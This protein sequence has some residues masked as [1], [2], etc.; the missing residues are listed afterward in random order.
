[1]LTG[2]LVAVAVAGCGG[3]ERRPAADS[4]AKAT[5]TP[6]ATPVVFCAAED[7]SDFEQGV[8]TRFNRLHADDGMQVRFRGIPDAAD[9]AYRFLANRLGRGC[10]VALPDVTWMGRFAADGRLLDVTDHVAPRTDEFIG[11]TLETARYHGRYWGVPAQADTG[12]LYYRTDATAAPKT[13]QDVYA[14]AQRKHGLLY[15]TAT[16]MSLAAHF[17]EVAYA[18]GG[19]VA[20][21]DG[22]HSTIDSPQNLRALE[23]M[24]DG[25][26]HG[27]VPKTVLEMNE[28]KARIAFEAGRATF[29]RNWPY[30]Y[31]LIHENPRV[32][33]RFAVAPLPAFAGHGAAGVL[34]GKDAV[35]AKTT[36]DRAA[37]L[38]F[39]DLLTSRKEAER[40]ARSYA[41]TPA[42]KAVYKTDLGS[43]MPQQDQIRRALEIA[44]P[45]PVTPAWQKVEEVIASH[46]YAVLIGNAPPELALQDAHRRIEIALAAAR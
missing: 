13:W 5:A 44:R 37:A 18:A 25:V 30:A 36:A 10:D 31:V 8:V 9:E 20:S 14:I 1:M 2:M 29:M 46:V 32:A 40:L 19:S 34:G 16:Q 27:A 43:D 17:L 45:R 7:G 38:A 41:G 26:A 3:T 12:L 24:R 28:E 11:R 23:L 6:D 22:R 4:T 42:L 21:R 35:V 39:V 15:Q 33:R